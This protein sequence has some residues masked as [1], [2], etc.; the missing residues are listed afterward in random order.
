VNALDK[1]LFAVSWGGYESLKLPILAFYDNPIR[2]NPP[3]PF[4]LIRIYIGLETAEYLIG[5]LRK[6]F[7]SIRNN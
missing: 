3:L 2:T 4:Q 1:F 6:A 7:D 5:N